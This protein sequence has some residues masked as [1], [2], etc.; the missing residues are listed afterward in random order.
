MKE[1]CM[2]IADKI[3]DIVD[4]TKC[5]HLTRSD[6]ADLLEEVLKS[7]ESDIAME[8]HCY[9]EGFD[10]GYDEGYS[11]GYHAAYE[12]LKEKIGDIFD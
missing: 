9:D 6:I 5:K 1:Y 4:T 11:E 2:E 7:R 8:A 10:D 3:L 12:N